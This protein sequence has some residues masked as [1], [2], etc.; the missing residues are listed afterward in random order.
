MQFIVDNHE[1]NVFT[2]YELGIGAGTPAYYSDIYGSV[3]NIFYNHEFKYDDRYLAQGDASGDYYANT[4]VTEG[5]E[6]ITFHYTAG[7]D[8]TA[9]TYN[10]A[11]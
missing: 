7:F 10:H 6:F 2:R 4:N 11:T 1:S 9:D 8:A 3:S 5:L